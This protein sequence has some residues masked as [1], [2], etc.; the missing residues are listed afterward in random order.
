MLVNYV[1]IVCIEQMHLCI[2]AYIEYRVEHT[3]VFNSFI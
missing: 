3:H 2:K 1:C